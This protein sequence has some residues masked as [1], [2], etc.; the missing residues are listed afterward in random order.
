MEINKVL[1]SEKDAL[2]QQRDR[3]VEELKENDRLVKLKEASLYDVKKLV[4]LANSKAAVAEREREVFRG[5]AEVADAMYRFEL[6][7]NS[8]LELHIN[9]LRAENAALINEDE[10]ERVKQLKERITV[11]TKEAG[12]QKESILA[13]KKQTADHD[14]IEKIRQQKSVD[15]QKENELL[16]KEVQAKDRQI[17]FY[18]QKIEIQRKHLESRKEQVEAVEKRAKI[19]QLKALEFVTKVTELEKSGTGSSSEEAEKLKNEIQELKKK[20]EEGESVISE[21]QSKV[22][23]TETVA[24][25]TAHA[26][27]T[28]ESE[29]STKIAELST[30]TEEIATLRKSMADLQGKL[31]ASKKTADEAVVTKKKTDEE[32][33]RLK[34]EL[35]ILT[36]SRRE[37]RRAACTVNE[38]IG[39]YQPEVASKTELLDASRAEIS[40]LSEQLFLTEEANRELRTT[41]Q[42]CQSELFM[43]KDEVASLQAQL[44][45]IT[46]DLEQKN[47]Q[48][49]VLLSRISDA[50]ESELKQLEA[51]KEREIEF[52]ELRLQLVEVEETSRVNEQK[53]DELQA[54]NDELQ[55]RAKQLSEANIQLTTLTEGKDTEISKLNDSIGVLKDVE[56]EGKEKVTRASTEVSASRVA[57]NARDERI[58]KL[59]QTLSSEKHIIKSQFDEL[60]KAQEESR[61]LREVELHKRDQEIESLKT[62][63]KTLTVKSAYYTER[64]KLLNVK[65][66]AAR[67]DV[68]V[69]V[70]QVRKQF[71]TQQAVENELT[72]LR[73]KLSFTDN[74][75]ATE[76]GRTAGLNDRLV[77]AHHG[78]EKMKNE[79]EKVMSLLK[80]M[81]NKLQETTDSLNKKISEHELSQIQYENAQILLRSRD[82]RIGVVHETMSTLKVDIRTKA[83]RLDLVHTKV[84]RL[85]DDNTDLQKKLKTLSTELNETK[86]KLSRAEDLIEDKELE[87]AKLQLEVKSR[88]DKIAVLNARLAVA[89]EELATQ[90]GLLD[91]QFAAGRSHLGQKA[92]EADAAIKQIT[93]QVKDDDGKTQGRFQELNG[94]V[95]QLESVLLAKESVVQMLTTKL[96]VATDSLKAKDETQSTD[97]AVLNAKI[98]VLQKELRDERSENSK[99]LQEARLMSSQV[100][101]QRDATEQFMNKL[102]AVETGSSTKEEQLTQ[103]QKLLEDMQSDL[104]LQSKKLSKI[105]LVEEEEK[106]E[107]ADQVDKLRTLYF[108]S[109]CLIAKIQLFNDQ[110]G[111]VNVM[112]ED[113]FEEVVKKNITLE[114][115]PAYIFHRLPQMVSDSRKPRSLFAFD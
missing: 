93:K 4:D 11:M 97:I 44:N 96:H 68:K 18:E 60:V 29:L 41:L 20:L 36:A 78:W 108:Q 22:K 38:A 32:A 83:E 28:L 3:A 101:A 86:D 47:A 34:S 9:R 50:R 21:E 92:A 51:L 40:R 15:L 107:L 94:K 79:H 5:K 7:R 14:K 115:W 66:A 13:L 87:I 71:E 95:Q 33:N 103:M 73:E 105:E 81:E 109:L 64:M 74:E 1:Q 39:D 89:K 35:A 88:E 106:R 111:T 90:L 56:A 30:A 76:R 67:E 112:S 53:A 42:T 16:K 70:Q 61:A 91:S 59:L 24:N 57:L 80:D 77:A 110:Q 8:T 23:A 10:D 114:E 19:L 52:Q 26:K 27:T 75:L 55:E 45:S 37:A 12:I 17:A 48:D 58:G 49:V 43:A 25:A 63:L 98:A 102:H 72:A 65:F 104:E 46:V 82:Q 6:D 62:N 2:A 54:L 69:R 84:K 113:L 85:A 99:R 31:V 100:K